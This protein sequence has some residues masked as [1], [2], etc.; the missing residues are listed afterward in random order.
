METFRSENFIPL[1]EKR[2]QHA[3]SGK[4]RSPSNS[5]G[6]GLQLQRDGKVVF[7]NPS[8][9]LFCDDFK[10]LDGLKGTFNN[11]NY[12]SVNQKLAGKPNPRTLIPP[13]I[14]PPAY[15]LGY[16]GANNLVSFPQIN[17]ESNIDVFR[18]GYQVSTCCPGTYNDRYLV[19]TGKSCSG[20]G[21]GNNREI[22]QEN[23]DQG[24]DQGY[25]QGHDQENN[26]ENN[27]EEYQ[28]PYLKT[29]Q[30]ISIRPNLPGQVNTNCGYN[31]S[32]LY[33]AGLPTNLAV[34]NCAKDPALKQYNENLFTQTIQPGIYSYNQVNEPIGSNIGISFQQQ[35]EPTTCQM[36]PV[37][38]E[39]L[40]TEHDPRIME[41]IEES[42]YIEGINESNV[43]DPRFTGYGTSY[44]AYT[45]DNLGQTKFYYD[46]VDAIRMPNYV[47]RSEIDNQP[48]ADQYG[49]A[50]DANGNPYHRDIRALANDAFTRSAV[51]FR[52]DLQERLTRK[53]RAE[54]WQQRVAPISTG[55]Q[56]MLGGNG[57]IF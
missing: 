53:I 29:E 5:N 37:T 49:P 19:P 41:P 39:T 57:R 24:Y 56:R 12:T 26:Q 42:P 31:P 11:T 6:C 3:Q 7:H 22:K 50:I 15:D 47:V 14:T 21:C 48:F 28:Y 33:R 16:W 40:Y 17:E 30:E 55:G 38:G 44:R 25:N 18:S 27:Q 46:D 45:D 2:K 54:A 1:P 34:G 51:G 20:G 9:K 36:D 52:T 43:Y 10:P 35:F 23:Y 8:S 13:I 4:F 32:Q